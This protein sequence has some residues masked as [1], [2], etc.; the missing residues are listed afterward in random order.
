MGPRRGKPR[1]VTDAAYARLRAGWNRWRGERLLGVTQVLLLGAVAL[2]GM[3]AAGTIEI[4]FTL[5]P[6]YALLGLAAL[7]GLPWAVDG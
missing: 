3:S 5:Q 2:L 1:P 7:S 4:T 6:S